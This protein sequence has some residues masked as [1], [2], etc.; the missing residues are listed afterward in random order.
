MKNK[1]KLAIKF[2]TETRNE[3]QLLIAYKDIDQFYE[4][5]YLFK[6]YYTFAAKNINKQI[7]SLLSEED[8]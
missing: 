8:K 7:F 1:Y 5:C 3:E 4:I 2:Y 6:Y